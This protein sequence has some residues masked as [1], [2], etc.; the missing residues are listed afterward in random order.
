LEQNSGGFFYCTNYNAI[1]L[2][3]WQLKIVQ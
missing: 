2:A 1:L 3:L